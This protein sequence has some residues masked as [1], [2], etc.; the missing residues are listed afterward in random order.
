M[1][2]SARSDPPHLK[3]AGRAWLR[4]YGPAAL[5]GYIALICLAVVITALFLHDREKE[6]TVVAA[7]LFGLVS[8]TT[9]AAAL[10]IGQHRQ[11]RYHR[12][13]TG[14]DVHTNRQ[15]VRAVALAQQWHLTWEDPVTQ[16]WASASGAGL[17]RGEIVAV[18]FRDGEVA[19]AS[20]CDPAVGF[21]LVGRRRC[22]Q[23]RALLQQALQQQPS[24]K[25][26]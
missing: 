13:V 23:H 22:L 7:G 6:L 14:H 2:A 5:A 3:L 25:S 19:I 11:L 26:G 9:L 10:W 24:R 1:T 4:H 15:R 8:S 21:S 18:R 17:H 16:H 12:I 20:F